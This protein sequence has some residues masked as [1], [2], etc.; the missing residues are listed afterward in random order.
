LYLAN[1]LRFCGLVTIF[2]LVPIGM[3][4]PRYAASFASLGGD[5][6]PPL[7]R[8][9]LEETD[10]LAAAVAGGAVID[11]GNGP[12]FNIFLVVELGGRGIPFQFSETSWRAFLGYRPW[13]LP[14]YD[15][16]M[17][18]SIVLRSEA[19]SASPGL[20]MRTTQF[21]VLRQP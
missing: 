8:F 3:G 13:P 2:L 4:L 15:K 20:I 5:A 14:R 17:P 12:H 19:N 10:Q 6:S 21:D 16:P 1:R 11:V 9:S 18:I 7:Y